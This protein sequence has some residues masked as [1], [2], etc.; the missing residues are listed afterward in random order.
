MKCKAH[1]NTYKHGCVTIDFDLEDGEDIKAVG[2]R[3][4]AGWENENDDESYRESYEDEKGV[5]H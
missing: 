3:V 1:L 5:L 2:D 4:V